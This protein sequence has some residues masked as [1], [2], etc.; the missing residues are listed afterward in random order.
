MQLSNI[1]FARRPLYGLLC[2]SSHHS[3]YVQFMYCDYTYMTAAWPEGWPMNDVT[4]GAEIPIASRECWAREGYA[5]PACY[6][7]Y[8]MYGCTTHYKTTQSG[9]SLVGSNSATSGP[10]DH[11]RPMQ[12]NSNQI[13][14]TNHT[15]HYTVIYI[16]IYINIYIC[17]YKS[18]RI[19][20]TRCSNDW[21][22]VTVV[23]SIFV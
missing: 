11:C 17:I 20:Y 14:R 18:D 7:D 12:A 9:T 15:T 2:D 13:Q 5:F 3:L 6:D 22:V 21:T 10:P 19:C 4:A 16:Y 8:V 23:Q 1:P